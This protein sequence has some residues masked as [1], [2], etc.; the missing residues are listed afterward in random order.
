MKIFWCLLLHNWTEW[1]LGE[2]MQKRYQFRHCK[3]CKLI[4]EDRTQLLW[5]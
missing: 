3:R 2:R 1:Q 4:Q 5:E